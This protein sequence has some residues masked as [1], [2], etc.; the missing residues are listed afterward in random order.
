MI[1]TTNE[2][3]GERSAMG[4]IFRKIEYLKR[5]RRRIERTDLVSLCC[6]SH[7]LVQF[8]FCFMFINYIKPSPISTLPDRLN[9]YCTVSVKREIIEKLI[10]QLEVWKVSIFLWQKTMEI[11]IFDIKLIFKKRL[12]KTKDIKTREKLIDQFELWKDS[13][14]SSQGLRKS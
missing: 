3:I 2:W 1:E 10:I 8:Q 4:R 6:S 13:I 11:R 9:K 7:P 5:K 12:V 14:F